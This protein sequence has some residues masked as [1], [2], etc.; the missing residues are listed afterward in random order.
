M[1]REEE[2]DRCKDQVEK[3]ELNTEAR[4][5]ALSHNP[6]WKISIELGGVSIEES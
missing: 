5:F 6:A 2:S 4:D 1:R 3:E